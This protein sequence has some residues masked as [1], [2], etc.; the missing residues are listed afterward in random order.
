MFAKDIIIEQLM[1]A[2]DKVN[3]LPDNSGRT[4]GLKIVNILFQAMRDIMDLSEGKIK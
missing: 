3:D 1:V 2:M 4:E